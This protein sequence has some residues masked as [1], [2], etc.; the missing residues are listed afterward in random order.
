MIHLPFGPP[1]VTSFH[2]SLALQPWRNILIQ[3]LPNSTSL[4]IT[5]WF[6]TFSSVWEKHTTF[7][8]LGNINAILS[9]AAWLMLAPSLMAVSKE[10]ALT[11]E[12]TD[13]YLLRTCA[14]LLAL[15]DLEQ[16]SILTSRWIMFQLLS[17]KRTII[18]IASLL[19]GVAVKND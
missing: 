2:N 6:P 13:R 4:G 10:F 16:T 18:A 5:K 12:S 8:I 17:T 19:S 15:T 14:S 11:P 9:S 3:R 1:S 7:S